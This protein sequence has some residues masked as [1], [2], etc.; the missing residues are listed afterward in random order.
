M[1]VFKKRFDP[2][3]K[4]ASHVSRKEMPD[5]ELTDDMRLL[6]SQVGEEGL[7][8]HHE[9]QQNK[10]RRLQRPNLYY[11]FLGLFVALGFSTAIF[12]I[13]LSMTST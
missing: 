4:L 10:K 11:I 8:A 3:K 2:N 13:I 12:L 7:A 5:A 6:M 1:A 9:S